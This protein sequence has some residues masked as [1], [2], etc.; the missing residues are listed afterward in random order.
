L[1]LSEKSFTPFILLI[2]DFSQ[3]F[4]FTEKIDG[5]KVFD[6]RH[7]TTAQGMFEAL[8][9]HIKYGTNKGNIR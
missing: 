3:R 8:C 2:P 4:S 6:A 9:N 1:I 5:N 7:V